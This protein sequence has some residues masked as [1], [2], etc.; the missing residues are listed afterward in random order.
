MDTAIMPAPALT[1]TALGSPPP[2]LPAPM[3]GSW[4]VGSADVSS[5]ASVV[6]ASTSLNVSCELQA[7]YYTLYR[8]V[9]SAYCRT[10]MAAFRSR[11]STKPQ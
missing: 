8:P 1:L 5:A 2:Q 3:A 9:D 10:L 4:P 6:A 11:S 7:T